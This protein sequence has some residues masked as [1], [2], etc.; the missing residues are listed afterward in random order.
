MINDDDAALVKYNVHDETSQFSTINGKDDMSSLTIEEKFNVY[1][2]YFATPNSRNYFKKN[3]EGTEKVN[4][5]PPPYLVGL[6]LCNTNSAYKHISIDEI[7]VHLIIEKF[8]TTLKIS[9]KYK[10]A[11]ILNLIN[12][13]LVNHL[14]QRMDVNEKDE[15]V[16]INCSE[17]QGWDDKLN[18]DYVVNRFC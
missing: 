14:S 15:C 8:V 11:L 5:P 10:F 17:L 4:A 18:C 1:T 2:D 12:E 6:A 9:Q 3:F 7:D 13:K 16:T